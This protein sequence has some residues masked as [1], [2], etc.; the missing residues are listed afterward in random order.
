[1]WTQDP[2]MK[3]LFRVIERVADSDTT[4]LVRG[5]TGAG[6]ELV[7]NALHALSRR[8]HGPLRALNCAALPAHLLESELFGHARGAFTGAL[9]DTPGHIQLAHGGT[10]FL[11]E[12]AELP[13]ELLRVLETRTVLPVG[14][15]EPI[16]VDVRVISATRRTLRD[17]SAGRAPRHVAR[18]ATDWPGRV[19]VGPRVR[20]GWR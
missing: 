15:R 7:A 13:L 2:Q 17:G 8:R 4:V 10:L 3:P 6:K 18:A 5:E 1:M 19:R 16:P 12:V 20:R 14:A 11:D 9:R